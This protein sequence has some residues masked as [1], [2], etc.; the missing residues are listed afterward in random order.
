MTVHQDGKRMRLRVPTRS[1]Q[2]SSISLN[3]PLYFRKRKRNGLPL[4]FF[5]FK[6]LSCNPFDIPTVERHNRHSYSR[7]NL[8]RSKMTIWH[9]S[10]GVS[11]MTESSTISSLPWRE[12][13]KATCL[14]KQSDNY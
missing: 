7:L 5:V 14:S 9:F 8:N 2:I 4:I 3:T 10:N 6:L 13:C 12:K 1:D 11:P